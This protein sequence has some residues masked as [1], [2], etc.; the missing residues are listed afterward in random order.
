MKIK[1]SF[2]T[3]DQGR[4]IHKEAIPCAKV[5]DKLRDYYSYMSTEEYVSWLEKYAVCKVELSIEYGPK[6]IDSIEFEEEDY[7]VFLLKY[8]G[9]LSHKSY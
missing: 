3:D 8:S 2:A 9:H 6:Y 4:Y 7:T 1:I 5:L